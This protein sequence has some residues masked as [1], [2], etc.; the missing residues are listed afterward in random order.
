[1][2]NGS[3]AEQ[4]KLRLVPAPSFDE[5]GADFLVPLRL[6]RTPLIG[7]ERDAERV[8][9]LLLREDV[10][11]V[12]L[13]GPG[14]VGKT[15]LALQVAS[16]VTQAFPDGVCLV[17]LAQTRDPAL[18]LPT[19]ARALGLSD[20]GSQPL[21]ERLVGYLRTAQLLLVLDNV[22]QVV[23]A[24]PVVADLLSLCPHVKV[25][26]TSRVVLRLSDEHDVPVAPLA[27][28]ERLVLAD[29]AAA[30][31]VQLFVS[32]ARASDPAFELTEAN[33]ATVATICMRLD[34]LPLALELAAARI[35]VL[36][37]AALLARLEHTL[38][39]LTGGARDQPERLRTMRAAIAWSFDLLTSAE[40]RFASRLAVFAGGFE[41]AA[42]EAVAD[43]GYDVLEGIATLID[44]S[45]LRMVGGPLDDEPR[46][47]MLATIRE[48][49]SERLAA[50]GAEQATRTAHAAYMLAFAEQTYDR[51]FGPGYE[52][53]LA[54]LDAEHDNFR[55]ALTWAE[56]AGDV[57][58]SLRLARALAN[59]WT[60]HGHFREGRA[61]LARA[62]TMG[63]RAPSDE[64]TRALFAAAWLARSQDDGAAAE[65]L[66]TEALE[67]AETSGDRAAVAM[68]LQ[69]LGQV[70][71]QRGEIE[72]AMA[73]TTDALA[74]YQEVAPAIRATSPFVSLIYANLGQIAL[75]GGHTKEAASNLA[76]AEQRQRALGFA[77]GLGD[78]LRYLGDLARV[79][80][81]H[82]RAL[83]YYRESL[84]LARDH[85][86]RRFL[87]ET[88]AGIAAT[89][90][91][92]RRPLRA[93]GLY[94]AAA[95]L[96]EQ[97]GAPVEGW[98]LAGY[99]RGVQLVRAALAPAAFASAWAEGSAM[100][101]EV[102][103][104]EAL[105]GSDEP[106][107]ADSVAAKGLTPR[108]RDVLRLLAQGLSDRE[109]GGALHISPR[110]VGGH[111]T[112]LL[113]KLGVDS[114]TA[115]AAFAVRHGLD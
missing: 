66:L 53:V 88:L 47:Q 19:I 104:A 43:P 1:M 115:A 30:P 20:M 80:R 34:G 106:A 8:R 22:E 83:G 67:F 31:A 112:N 84:E 35:P 23:E 21:A 33:A 6:P 40:Q 102:V 76:E 89:A 3:P 96:R 14:G 111:V 48:F 81:D 98:E 16:D 107:V 13:T 41:P 57:N 10:A 68:A 99:R 64:R 74:T 12:T 65:P 103:I 92:Q 9:D 60:V 109:I 62:L 94:G 78:T 46:Y 79:G 91:E 73:S 85:G 58:L 59:Y 27:A 26:A 45:L 101:L 29:V 15:R 32:R 50:S 70:H 2:N 63:D 4:P 7:R 93:A 39:L 100:P 82:E 56:T 51:F 55:A 95:T 77:W 25:L 97:I 24:A 18:V 42:A 69:A 37:P 5:R 87:A 105:A 52:R 71:L 108:E 28:P 17:A 113:A 44:A 36:P 72:R 110:T 86:D 11:L 61:W 90:A 49:G 38:P 114:R 54:R 75:A